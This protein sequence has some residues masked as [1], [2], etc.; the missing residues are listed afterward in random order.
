MTQVGTTSTYTASFNLANIPLDSYGTYALQY[1]I[2]AEDVVGNNVTTTVNSL[3]VLYQNP[4]GGP[5][6]FT[7]SWGAIIGASA[8]GIVAIIAVL[9][10]WINRH[11]IQTFAKKQTFRRR[12]RDYLREI[13][14]DIKRDGLEGRYKEGLLKTWMVVEGIGR[15]FYNLPR[16]RS[17]TPMEFSRLLAQKGKIERELLFTLLEYFTKARYGYEEITEKDFNSGIRALLK[18]VDKIEVGEMQI[19]S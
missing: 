14:E 15:E 1:H 3:S 18:I 10:L 4:R 5:G 6:G 11:T 7:G 12:L 16:Y 17:Q 19:E 2:F 8:G 13:I 9:F